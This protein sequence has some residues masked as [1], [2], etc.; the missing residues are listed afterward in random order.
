MKIKEGFLLREVAGNYIVIAA[1]DEG[2]NFNNIITVNELGAIIWRGIEDEKTKE[3]IIEEILLEYDIDKETA[4]KDFDE[5]I[6]QLTDAGV[7]E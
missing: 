1:G 6:G 7:I 3:Q 4:A 5:F 2:L